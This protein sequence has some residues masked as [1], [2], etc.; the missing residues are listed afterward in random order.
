MVHF[1]FH[2]VHAAT[3][4]A[5][6]QCE[7][8]PAVA[9][10]C[11]SFVQKVE[12]GS[13]RGSRGNSE[14]PVVRQIEHVCAELQIVAL[15]DLNV[16]DDVEINADQAV[17]PQKIAWNVARRISRRR[18][19]ICCPSAEKEV[20]YRGSGLQHAFSD[21]GHG[22]FAQL[23]D[24]DTWREIRTNRTADKRAKQHAAWIRAIEYRKRRAA[25]ESH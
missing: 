21:F 24:V 4:K 23:V 13:V 12:R 11:R 8:D 20:W 3:L 10:V 18:T 1:T 5:I 14:V 17:R 19:A 9:T 7:K 2:R 22:H 25:L 16:L 6:P 15:A